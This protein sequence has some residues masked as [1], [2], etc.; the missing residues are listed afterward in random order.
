MSMGM[1]IR[2]YGCMCLWGMG[3]PK[4]LIH[5]HRCNGPLGQQGSK[6]V[7][8]DITHMK[9]DKKR[10]I[11]SNFQSHINITLFNHVGLFHDLEICQLYC[12]GPLNKVGIF[13]YHPYSQAG[14]ENLGGVRLPTVCTIIIV[15]PNIISWNYYS[16]QQYHLKYQ[17]SS[18]CSY[19]SYWH[20]SLSVLA[21]FSSYS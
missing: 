2:A 19:C 1:D 17:H 6:L 8:H 14:I 7:V 3:W 13:T 4:K 5:M 10:W 9:H 11:L 21:S 12:V 18:Q 15:H 20:Y 16:G